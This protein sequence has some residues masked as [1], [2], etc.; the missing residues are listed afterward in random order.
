MATV[1]NNKDKQQ[2]SFIIKRN[3]NKLEVY[4]ELKVYPPELELDPKLNI[5]L[6]SIMALYRNL[7]E[8]YE[9]R[10]RYE[11]SSE[12]FT[13]EMEL[14]RKYREVRSLDGSIDLKDRLRRNF[15]LTGVYYN[16]FRY[17]ESLKRIALTT[18]ALFAVFS[19]AYFVVNLISINHGSFSTALFQNSTTIF[20]NSTATTLEDM[21]QIKGSDLQPLDYII[22]IFSL[23]LIGIVVISL[24]RKFE[25]KVRH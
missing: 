2:Y 13:R 18:V 12:F 10:F 11:E 25:R 16:L 22:R 1:L 5:G 19:A 24:K 15:S 9:F 7:R 4:P 8:N 6:E 3:G 14:K 17:G 23:P 21:F 20:K